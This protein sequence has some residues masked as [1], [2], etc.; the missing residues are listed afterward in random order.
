[1]NKVHK[2]ILVG[3]CCIWN[4][5]P[6]K[7]VNLGETPSIAAWYRSL[8]DKNVWPEHIAFVKKIEKDSIDFL[9]V[10]V[11]SFEKHTFLKLKDVDYRKFA[12]SLNLRS[13][14]KRLMDEWSDIDSFT[15]SSNIDTIVIVNENE[16][17]WSIHRKTIDKGLEKILIAK[18]P[19]NLSSENL[20]DWFVE[21]IGFSGV[22]IDVRDKFVLAAC[23]KKL[24]FD[25]NVMVAQ[26]SVN[27]PRL[28]RNQQFGDGLLRFIDRKDDLCLFELVTEPRDQLAKGVKIIF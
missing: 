2:S 24:S 14:A 22:V 19:D 7:A 15:V 6:L 27:L 4:I 11:E 8:N 10:D 25:T 20:R 13:K 1:M 16:K 3:I 5:H 18:K 23:Y 12:R 28:N 9:D 26:K 21:K 17:R